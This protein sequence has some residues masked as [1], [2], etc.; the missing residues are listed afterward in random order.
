MAL[1]TRVP[2]RPV[3]NRGAN[4]AGQIGI[5][6][7]LGL[8]PKIAKRTPVVRKQPKVDVLDQ[9]TDGISRRRVR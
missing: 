6:R 8:A 2:A 7:D 3:S 9:I 1:L 4:Y 5:D